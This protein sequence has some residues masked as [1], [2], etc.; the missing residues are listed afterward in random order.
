MKQWQIPSR[1]TCQVLTKISTRLPP[2]FTSLW[3]QSR[4]LVT[5]IT[6]LRV[7]LRRSWRFSFF[8]FRWFSFPMF[9]SN[10]LTFSKKILH[11]QPWFRSSMWL[12]SDSRSSH[13]WSSS[14]D[15]WTISPYPQV[16]TFNSRISSITTSRKTDFWL[17]TTPTISST[18]CL[19]NLGNPCSSVTCSM[20]FSATS[21]S[22]SDPINTWAE[23]FSKIWPSAWDHDSLRGTRNRLMELQ[24]ISTLSTERVKRFKR[25]FWSLLAR[26]VQVTTISKTIRWS[27]R[28]PT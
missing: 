9:L 13:G 27:T 2:Y 1:S 10:S 8:S 16:L 18:T 19:T 3:Q 14:S 22:F 7:I 12:G 24:V 5:V 28:K 4:R 11:P 6:S 20:M 15:T 23:S 17:W 25:C 26:S 21:E